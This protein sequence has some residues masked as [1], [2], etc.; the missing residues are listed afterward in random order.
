MTNDE[1]VA[2]V[3]AFGFSERR[4]RFLLL[5]LEHA[6]VCLPRQY[7]TFAGIAHGRQTHDFFERL[8]R[9]GYATTDAT[10]PVHAG[11]IFHVHY[12]PL[13]RAIGEPDHR[14]RKPMSVGRAVERLMVL[15]GVLAGPSVT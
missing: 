9:D 6:G 3:R 14:H 11:R 8:V 12:K 10:A 5:V 13:Y 7:R 4:A 15:D 1:R 2:A